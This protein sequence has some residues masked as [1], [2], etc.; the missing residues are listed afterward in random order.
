MLETAREE[1]D[2]I[3]QKRGDNTYNSTTWTWSQSW[4]PHISEL[5]VE[6]FQFRRITQ[7]PKFNIVNLKLFYLVANNS[8]SRELDFGGGRE[9]RANLLWTNNLLSWCALLHFSNKYS[10]DTR[11]WEQ[12]EDGKHHHVLFVSKC[13]WQATEKQLPF[14]WSTR[15]YPLQLK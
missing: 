14:G 12:T 8:L 3:L 2:Q 9:K 7:T 13:T 4:L 5:A 1:P 15:Q 11:C 6:G 10:S